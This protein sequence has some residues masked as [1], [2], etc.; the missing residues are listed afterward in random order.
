VIGNQ[1]E[2]L[3]VDLISCPRG[4]A[5]AAPNISMAL[6]RLYMCIMFAERGD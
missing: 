6:A 5:I 1:D 3:P 2:W 4:A